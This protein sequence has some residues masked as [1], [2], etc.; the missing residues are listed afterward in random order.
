MTTWSKVG[1][2]PYAQT[3]NISLDGTTYNIRT[4]WNTQGQY[5]M[6]DIA[7]VN[8]VPLANGI[9]LVTGEDLLGQL[10]YLGFGFVFYVLTDGDPYATPTYVNL[11]ST[12]NLYVGT[13]P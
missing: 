4:F 12:S 6:M 2:K 5:W 8:N 1:L 10:D 11:G 7:D 9:P 13:Q 3:F